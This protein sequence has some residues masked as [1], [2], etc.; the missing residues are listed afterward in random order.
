M[1]FYSRISDYYN[2]I[3]PLN[4]AQISFVRSYLD[5]V[6]KDKRML[7]IG[8]GTGGLPIGL[9]EDFDSISAIDT[10]E[11][12]LEIAKQ[13]VGE[14]AIDFINISM[15]DIDIQFPANNFD[16]VLC[17]GNTIV[18][19]QNIEEIET[20]FKKVRYVLKQGGKFLFQLIN[21][22]NVLDNNLKGLP[23]IENDKIKFERNYKLDENNLI[24]FSTI[25]TIKETSEILKNNVKLFP[26]R[27]RQIEVA[28]K[29]A[30]FNTVKTYSSFTKNE[31]NA[32]SLPL[33]FECQ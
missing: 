32:S 30:G 17:F 20:F 27:K 33:V 19:L 1:D 25:L 26:V 22:D 15:L 14:K 16:V 3:F 12:M 6:S 8:C 21:Y 29:N 24:I 28:L 7:D 4:K 9:Y 11:E 31:Y 13:K 18:H 2:D 5:G 23:T 10:N